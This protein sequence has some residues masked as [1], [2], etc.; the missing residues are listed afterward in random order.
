MSEL[1]GS[2]LDGLGAPVA[3]GGVGN[4]RNIRLRFIKFGSK[5]Q[6]VTNC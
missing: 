2:M 6:G 5:K 3:L 1:L 4:P